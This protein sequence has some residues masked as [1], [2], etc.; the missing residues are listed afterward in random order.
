MLKDMLIKVT[1]L[2]QWPFKVTH[3]ISQAVELPTQLAPEITNNL[4]L[5]SC[6][7]L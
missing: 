2:S 7:L 5:F 4:Y 6:F 3:I 1:E